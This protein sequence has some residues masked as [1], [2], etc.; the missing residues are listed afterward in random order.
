VLQ[1]LGGNSVE[2]E[3]HAQ[4][5]IDSVIDRREHVT[6][7]LQVKLKLVPSCRRDSISGACLGRSGRRAKFIPM[8]G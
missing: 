8:T 7:P 5:V 4:V 1:L 6:E 3:G 2:F